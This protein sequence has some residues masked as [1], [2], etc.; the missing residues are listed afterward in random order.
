M[1]F[2]IDLLERQEKEKRDASFLI[3]KA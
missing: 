1:Q 2:M 3:P